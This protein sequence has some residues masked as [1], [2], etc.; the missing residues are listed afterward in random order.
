[1]DF[2]FVRFLGDVSRGMLAPEF[3]E[4]LNVYALLQDFGFRGLR[5]PE[6][7]HFIQ[8]FIYDDKI[9]SDAFF[10]QFFEI[11]GEDLHDAVKEK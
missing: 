11:L 6:I 5:I 3:P 4:Q 7:H 10:L 8:Q 9:V 1:M 2:Q